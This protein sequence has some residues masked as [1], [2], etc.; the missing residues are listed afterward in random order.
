VFLKALFCYKLRVCVCVQCDLSVAELFDSHPEPLFYDVFMDLGGGEMRK[1]LPLPTLVKNQ[2]YN[3]RF[4][5]Q[6]EILSSRLQACERLVYS[7]V[8]CILYR[9][10]EELVPVST[11]SSCGHAEWKREELKLFT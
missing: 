7:H 6:G 9:E 4:I 5:N 2:Q 8:C 11:H 10:H 3:G 1:L